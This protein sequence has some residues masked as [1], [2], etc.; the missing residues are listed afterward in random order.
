MS[1]LEGKGVDFADPDWAMDDEETTPLPHTHAPYLPTLDSDP[2]PRPR[3]PTLEP[4]PHHGLLRP[5]PQD[6]DPC[7]PPPQTPNP[8]RPLPL[9][10]P[11]TPH[12]T[13]DIPFSSEF[14]AVRTLYQYYPELREHLAETILGHLK[15]EV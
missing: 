15:Q 7:L 10:P 8:P 14:F 3:S 5:P 1:Y 12:P 13:Q 6:P 2:Y 11:P 9:P 4:S